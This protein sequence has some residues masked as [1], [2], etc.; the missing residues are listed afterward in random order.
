MSG[1][2]ATPAA[3]PAP[4]AVRA[5]FV[6]ELEEGAREAE[7]SDAIPAQDLARFHALNLCALTVPLEFGGFGL[8]PVDVMPYL[9]SA[10]MGP[11]WGRM[12]THVANGIWRPG[13]NL[14]NSK[15]GGGLSSWPKAL[16]FQ[17]NPNFVN[18][19]D[20]L[21]SQS[22]HT[23]GVTVGLGDGSVRFVSQGISD[24][25]WAAV[26]DPRDRAVVGNNW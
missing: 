21:R 12:L 26:N 11:A 24:D 18:A 4:D 13:V 16:M 5:L 7:E 3:P 2:E 17:V 1:P 15:G 23:T 6:S 14:G 8:A 19:C 10:G 22:G 25:V 9:E 20:P